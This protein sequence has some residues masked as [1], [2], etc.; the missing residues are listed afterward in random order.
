MTSSGTAVANL[1]PAVVEA[2][3]SN[4][5]LLLLTADRPFEMR[6]TGANQ[7]ID[8]VK[9]FGNYTR[10]DCDIE[11]PYDDTA[12]K[13][14]VQ[15]IDEAVQATCATPSGPVHLNCQFREPLAPQKQSFNHSTCMNGLETWE[16]SD[17]TLEECVAAPQFNNNG[18]ATPLDPTLQQLLATVRGARRGLLVIGELV[19]PEDVAAAVQIA[20]LLGWPVAAD[21]L[22]GLRVGA[23]PPQGPP[24]NL[25]SHFDH[26]L[27]DPMHWE[28]FK[29]DVV[30]QLGGHLV[31][32]RVAQFLE[33]CAA[34]TD[35]AKPT[36]WLFV[37]RAPL[38]QDQGP[39]VTL[40]FKSSVPALLA[41]LENESTSE[42]T[43]RQGVAR[44]AALQ[45]SQYSQVLTALDRD[46][47]AAVDSALAQFLELTEPAVARVLSQE[48]PLGEGLF[49]GNSMP[50]RD[51]DM[52]G[53]PAAVP[54]QSGTMMFDTSL[55][56]FQGVV[57]SGLGAPVA[58]NRGAS[59]IDGVLSTAAG[60]AD[61]LQRGT[62]L[63]V[64]D[65]SFLHDVN[66]L[67]LLR[68][69][70]WNK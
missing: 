13:T 27:L 23:R 49:I 2:S 46:A 54:S 45:Q 57:H 62:T 11:A 59:G 68:S 60:F 65:I 69:G 25:I 3:Q 47:S 32:K 67:N 36:P 44:S 31:S 56:E 50:I 64:G 17:R 4:V 48:L 5:P 18:A 51:L 43:S 55:V 6:E 42:S 14:A 53:I 8:Q 34:P 61:G 10:W 12:A 19:D 21:V 7:T 22:S 41:A 15:T 24:F 33:W 63:V 29:P 40:R 35:G 20:Q 1:L 38:R 30:L 28:Y 39:L 66:G 16:T 58:A 9:I 37:S 52:Y 26:L 70:E